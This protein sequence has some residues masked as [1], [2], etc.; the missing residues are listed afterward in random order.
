MK[1]GFRQK[2]VKPLRFHKQFH[3]TPIAPWLAGGAGVAALVGLFLWDDPTR[4][5]LG[6]AAA[7]AFYVAWVLGRGRTHVLEIT[8]DHV[9]HRG[10]RTWRVDRQAI[11]RAEAG[12]KGWTDDWDPFLRLHTR[13]GAFEVEAGFLT[14]EAR[15]EEIRA[16]LTLPATAGPR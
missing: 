15:V 8:P 5:G 7:F 1:P 14:S 3:G 6:A 4:W 11:L 9:H 16:A 10:F 12:R 13:D 2:N